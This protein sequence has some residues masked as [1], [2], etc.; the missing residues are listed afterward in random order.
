MHVRRMP[1]SWITFRSRSASYA[2]K[3]SKSLIGRSARRAAP[4][5]PEHS[6]CEDEEGK[7]TWYCL[8]IENSM[9]L[10]FE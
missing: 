4:K 8:R 6:L 2:M 1:T 10:A 9:R 7:V 3:L 5:V